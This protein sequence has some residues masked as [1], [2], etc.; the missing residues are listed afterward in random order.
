MEFEIGDVIDVS[1]RLEVNIPEED[2]S[3][4][5][6]E[7]DNYEKHYYVDYSCARTSSSCFYDFTIEEGFSINDEIDSYIKEDLQKIYPEIAEYEIFD[8]NKDDFEY[9]SAKVRIKSLNM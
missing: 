4:S 2:Y 8:V 1:I 3:K 9:Q 6:I 5:I 7:I